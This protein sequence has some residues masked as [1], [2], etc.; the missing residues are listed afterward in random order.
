MTYEDIVKIRKTFFTG[1]FAK[2]HSRLFG[3]KKIT[4]EDVTFY[5]NGEIVTDPKEL[6][7]RKAEYREEQK[8]GHISY[9]YVGGNVLPKEYFD[10]IDVRGE[11]YTFLDFW[12]GKRKIFTPLPEEG[13][14]RRLIR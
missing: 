9:E 7:K 13:K 6:E 4:A 10:I 14:I 3:W 12:E 1:S 11:R 2:E 8:A 5:S